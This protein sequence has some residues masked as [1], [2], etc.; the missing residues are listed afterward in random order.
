MASRGTLVQEGIPEAIVTHPHPKR[1]HQTPSSTTISGGSSYFTDKVG[2]LKLPRVR[3]VRGGEPP[4]STTISGG[5][6]EVAGAD[7]R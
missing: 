1:E 2:G 6:D 5:S 7:L 4:N 3:L